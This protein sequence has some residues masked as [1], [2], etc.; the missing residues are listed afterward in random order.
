M[1]GAEAHTELQSKERVRGRAV[2]ELGRRAVLGGNGGRGGRV[3]PQR[4]RHLQ[5]TERG[6]VG[7]RR[8]PASFG[9]EAQGRRAGRREA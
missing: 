9:R 8:G 4:E 3:A 1:E 2:R 5:G 6:G 7:R